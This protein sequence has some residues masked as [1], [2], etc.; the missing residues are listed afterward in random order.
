[1]SD[2]KSTPKLYADPMGLFT[3]PPPKPSAEN[4]P[5][6][7]SGN[8][9]QQAALKR[10]AAVINNAAIQQQFCQEFT[11]LETWLVFSEAI[12]I[13]IGIHPRDT[14]NIGIA[15]ISAFNEAKALAKTGKDKPLNLINPNDQPALWRVKPADF[16][17]WM[18]EQKLN[19]LQALKYLF[20]NLEQD[21]V[22]QNNQGDTVQTAQILGAA[23]AILA[24]AP[25]QCIDMNGKVSVD[26]IYNL[27]KSK[28]NVWFENGNLPLEK[29]TIIKLLTS[30]IHNF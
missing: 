2:P 14:A 10:H 26:A 11:H 5:N 4:L 3:E 6:K 22:K 29:Q 21:N 12:P 13:C 17:H 15:N 28:A 23:L 20:L 18:V 25:T 24:N 8:L 16:V 27:M 1:M 19:P 9:A 30:T 7:R